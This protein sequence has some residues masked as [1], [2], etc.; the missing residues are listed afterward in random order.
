MRAGT[1]ALILGLVA[2]TAHAQSTN[3]VDRPWQLRLAAGWQDFNGGAEDTTGSIDVEI[4]PSNSIG[5]E[6]GLAHRWDGWEG[7]VD[8]GYAKG[9]FW[10]ESDNLAIKDKT[11]STT[12]LRAAFTIARRIASF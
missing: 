12:R 6:L 1:L 2:V 5:L 9:V 4:R 3:P 8:L 10:G 11:T 7:R